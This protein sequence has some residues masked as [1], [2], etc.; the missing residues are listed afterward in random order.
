M[1]PKIRAALN[2]V[3]NSGKDAIITCASNLG[4]K[5]SGTHIVMV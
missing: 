4:K 5:D 3:E 1:A 2:F